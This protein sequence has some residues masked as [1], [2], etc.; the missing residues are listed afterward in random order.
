M[1]KNLFPSN[2]MKTINKIL[3]ASIFVLTPQQVSSQELKGYPDLRKYQV[4]AEFVRTRAGI[5]FD[6]NFDT[7]GDN[8]PDI[9]YRY[10][11]V[12]ASDTKIEL[13][14]PIFFWIDL[15]RNHD[16][17]QEELYDLIKPKEERL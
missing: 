9:A 2:K 14:K 3:L 12:G 16:F 15:N 10:K 1:N 13:S 4:S 5:Y 8:F 11:V 7:D 17:E 6:I